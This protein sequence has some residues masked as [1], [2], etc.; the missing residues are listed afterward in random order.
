[1]VK[2]N[3]GDLFYRVM[4]KYLT[5]CGTLTSTTDEHF[6]WF[7][8][9][10]HRGLYQALVIDEFIKLGRLCLSVQDKAAAKALVFE[11]LD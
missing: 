3:H 5:S 1:M 2:V 6:L 11:Y 10:Y 9:G 8:M 4:A 7:R